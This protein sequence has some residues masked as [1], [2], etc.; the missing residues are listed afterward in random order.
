MK[1]RRSRIVLSLVACVSLTL[2]GC[3]IPVP[4]DVKPAQAGVASL[5]PQSWYILWAKDMPDHPATV[6]N[7][8]WSFSFPDRNGYVSYVQTPFNALPTNA[9]I[10][11]TFRIDCTAD[12]RFNGSV[13]PTA[14]DPATLHLFLETQND[15]FLIYTNRWWA[16]TGGFTLDSANGR[17]VTISVPLNWKNWSDTM[18]LQDPDLFANALQNIGWVGMTFGGQKSWGHGVNMIS[19]MATFTLIDF[20]VEPVTG[21]STPGVQTIAFKQE[22]HAWLRSDGVQS[23]ARYNND[24]ARIAL[25]GVSHGESLHLGHA[26]RMFSAQIAQ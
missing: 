19:G 2:A 9:Q 23:P 5:N 25:H 21:V 20:R 17:D 26:I 18:G 22:G 6:A 10:T 13:D 4:P 24:F 16:D 12:A 14:G 1:I 8:A 3:G 7:G 11:M 15:N